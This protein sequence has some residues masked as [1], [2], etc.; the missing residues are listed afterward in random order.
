M[1]G[2]VSARAGEATRPRA[3]TGAPAASPFV[4]RSRQI[5]H[6]EGWAGLLRRA[7][8]QVV[9]HDRECIY[10]LRLAASAEAFPAEL[11]RLIERL[12]KRFTVGWLRAEDPEEMA[13]YV[14]Y[15]SDL[16]RDAIAAFVAAG[17][18]AV[19]VRDRGRIVGDGWLAFTAFPF[20]DAAA[21]ASLE[22]RGY[23]FTF[24]SNVASQYAGLG[25]FPLLVDEQLRA[26]RR[27]GRLGLVGTVSRGN[28][29]SARSV[30]KMGFRPV[31]ALS[32]W[33]LMGRKR[34][35]AHFAC[36]L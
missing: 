32:I 34:A 5:Y 15:R 30:E 31:G 35:R 1:S 36:N 20:S 6:D 14:A 26:V 13:E 28:A 7:V 9:K 33:W 25:V 2:R 29:V 10:T 3:T 16:G 8:F 27:E 19:V 11:S 21:S 12:R 22:A 23:A 18:R 4:E 24:L 17:H